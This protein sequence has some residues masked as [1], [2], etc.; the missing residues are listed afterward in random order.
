MARCR[1]QI[2]FVGA[3]KAIWKRRFL[4]R[5]DGLFA[6]E[7]LKLPREAEDEIPAT[8]W[9]SAGIRSMPLYRVSVCDDSRRDVRTL[10]GAEVS[11][12]SKTANR[13]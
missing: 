9:K 10:M 8:L 1:A 11:A 3:E 2:P 6:L 4:F 7:S 12:F 13:Y 5:G